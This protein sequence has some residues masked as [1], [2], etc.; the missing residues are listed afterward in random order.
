VI[1]TKQDPK[2]NDFCIEIKQ[3]YN[4]FMKVITLP[5]S[6]DYGNENLVHDILSNLEMQ[7]KL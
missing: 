7:M 6:F 5:P 4:L 3:D 1:S 2:R